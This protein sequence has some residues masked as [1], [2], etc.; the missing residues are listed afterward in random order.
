MASSPERVD[1]SQRD[2]LRDRALRGLYR[3][4]WRHGHRLPR[5]L[6]AVVVKTAG[7]GALR[8]NGAHVQTLRRNLGVIIGRPADDRL[9]RSAIESYL[10][11]FAEVL[12]L[13]GWSRSE[14]LRRVRTLNGDVLLRA[15]ADRGAVVALPHSGNWD[16]AGAWACVSGM[17]VTTVAEQLGDAEFADFVAFRQRLGMEV[18]SHRDPSVIS[19]LVGAVRR[20]RL[21]CLLADRDLVDTGLTVRWGTATIT[22]PA[23]PAIVARRSGAALIPA[24]CRF[25]DEGMVIVFGDAI[26]P[27][28]G[29]DGLQAMLQEVADFFATTIAEAPQDWHML[30]PFFTDPEI[31]GPPS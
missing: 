26:P 15:Y 12:A 20:G 24:V 28:L 29:R 13:P 18:L 27:R 4:G 3:F 30:Q 25:T 10:R 1:R 8:H 7:A 22:M 11:A 17:P 21:V 16:L 6:V 14:I 9:L 31:P 23:G 2:D 19:E 5:R